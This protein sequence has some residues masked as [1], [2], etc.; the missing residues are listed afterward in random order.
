MTHHHPPT[1]SGLTLLETLLA[2]TV[3]LTLAAFLFTSSCSAFRHTTATVDGHHIKRAQLR[4]KLT[5]IPPA[6]LLDAATRHYHN[7]I[8]IRTCPHP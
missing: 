7:T 1:R 2:L 6:D 3:T 5:D 8:P 4:K